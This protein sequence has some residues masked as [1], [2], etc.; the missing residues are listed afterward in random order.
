MADFGEEN[1]KCIINENNENEEYLAIANN[2]GE[3]IEVVKPG[4]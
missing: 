3:I 2:H 1:V 4:K